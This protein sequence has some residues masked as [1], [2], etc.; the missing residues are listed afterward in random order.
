MKVE[1]RYIEWHNRIYL[2]QEDVAYYIRE[3]AC[4][5]EADLRDRL[6]T[7]VLNILRKT[8]DEI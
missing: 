7:A 8:I 5:E 6:E 3:V 2:R 4:G 1:M